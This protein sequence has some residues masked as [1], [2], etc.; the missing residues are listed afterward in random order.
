MKFGIRAC[1]CA[2]AALGMDAHAATTTLPPVRSAPP[3]VVHVAPPPV[4]PGAATPAIHLAPTPTQTRPITPPQAGAIQL[5]LALPNPTSGDLIHPIT[6]SAA[7]QPTA[8]IVPSRSPDGAQYIYR[9][10]PRPVF[11]VHPYHWPAG[12]SYIHYDA[13]QVLPRKFWIPQYWINNYAAYGLDD[14]ARDKRWV[15]YGPDLLLVDFRSGEINE[16]VRGAFRE[17]PNTPDFS[18]NG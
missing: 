13:H 1:L 5:H 6:P 14:P 18:S 15:R 17:D 4:V 12:S 11:V 3:P 10:V 7:Q 16:I 8:H 9:G 2:V